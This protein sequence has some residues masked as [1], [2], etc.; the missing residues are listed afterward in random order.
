[1]PR[2]IGLALLVT[3][4]LLPAC[5]KKREENSPA[6]VTERAPITEPSPAEPVKPIAEHAVATEDPPP[7]APTAE[8]EPAPPGSRDVPS[9]RGV[10]LDRAVLGSLPHPFGALEVIKPGASREDILSALPNARRDGDERI[11]VPVG[12]DD[13]V[14]T[15]DIDFAGHLDVVRIQLPESARALL[16]QAW[17]K[18]TENGT[19]FDRKKR[20]R[21]DL[22]GTELMIGAFTPLAELAGKGPDGLA[23]KQGIL[24]ES[25]DELKA[26]FGA[27]VRTFDVENDDGEKTGEK[28]I[29]LLT[30]ATDVCKYYTHTEG[31][32][33]G[34]RVVKLHIDQCFDDESQRRAAL[35]ALER[36]WGR[37]VPARSPQDLPVFT[38]TGVP[39]RKIE[40]TLGE[41]FAS[42]TGWKITIAK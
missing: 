16:A 3:A 39:G 11:V 18:P 24:G 29:E 22:D 27:R 1:M 36:V 15:I 28:R 40:M 14:A 21:A 35:A 5:K 38:F 9:E 37:A 10:P 13:L 7:P 6:P 33:A 26:R 12:V 2:R 42:H 8:P 4:A 34:G 20:W 31:E 19:W 17:G 23:E 25:P 41:I 30:P 32:L